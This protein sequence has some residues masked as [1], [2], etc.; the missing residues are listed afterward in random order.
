MR[1]GGL[2]SGVSGEVEDMGTAR[3][4]RAIEPRCVLFCIPGFLRNEWG[5]AFKLLR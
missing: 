4:S 3:A 5:H 1:V 2:G